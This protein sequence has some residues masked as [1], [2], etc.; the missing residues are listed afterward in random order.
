MMFAAGFGTRMGELTR[1]KPKPLI[2]VAGKTLL[3]H[4]LDLAHGIS[5]RRIVVNAHYHAD[6]IEEH[7]AGTD[8]IVS[9]EAPDILET[10]G[11]LRHALPLLG[12]GPVFTSNSDAIWKG[13]N[14]FEVLRD[15]WEP[16]RMDALLLC[17]PLDNAVGHAG[18]GDFLIDDEGRLTRGPGVVYGGIQILRTDTLADVSE[19]AFSLNKVW[20]LMSE[21]KRLFGLVYP[22]QWCDVGTPQGI[23]EAEEMLGARNV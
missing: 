22:G 13:P 5:P 16:E 1:N 18:K 11:G 19:S 14:P 21:N 6:M 9:H 2:E 10:G 7:L 15:A 20:T 3:D 8:V 4:S 17:V 23:I 12:E